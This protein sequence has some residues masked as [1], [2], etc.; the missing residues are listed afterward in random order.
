MVR[1]TIFSAIL[2]VLLVTTGAFTQTAVGAG[3]LDGMRFVGLN[4]EKGKPLD[5]NEE[6]EII[7]RDGLFTSV[8]CAP[9]NFG[10]AGYTTK[11]SGER[12]DFEAVTTSPTHGTISWQ[13]TVTGDRAEMNFVWTKERW[14]WS[15]RREYWFQGTRQQ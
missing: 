14:Y 9:Y 1:R 2:V 15:T 12:I 6:E 5:P 11:R 10:S 7:F 13:G 4:G 8:S 3:L